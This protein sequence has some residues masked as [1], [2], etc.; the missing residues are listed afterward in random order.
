M[1]SSDLTRR[2]HAASAR[3]C[4]ANWALSAQKT[5]GALFSAPCWI[6]RSFLFF[7]TLYIQNSILQWVNPPHFEDLYLPCPQQLAQFSIEFPS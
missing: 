1:S 5:K 4:D 2:S 3:S 7:F 6:D